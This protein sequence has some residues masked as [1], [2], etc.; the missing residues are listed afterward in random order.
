MER[1]YCFP[2]FLLLNSITHWSQLSGQIISR[3][4]CV[5]LV[6]SQL[7]FGPKPSCSSQVTVCHSRGAVLSLSKGLSKCC[8]FIYAYFFWLIFKNIYL[9]LRE[10]E[11]VCEQGCKQGRGRGRE[12]QRIQSG[13][14]TDSREPYAG[15]E[16]INHE[17]TTW[18]EVG[19]L[20]DWVIQASLVDF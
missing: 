2:S 7:I 17:I 20:T 4:Y 1:S 15:L 14:C 13:L 19:R 6:V 11:S 12:I 3:F 9:F 5:P 18:A 10:R 8:F 16:L